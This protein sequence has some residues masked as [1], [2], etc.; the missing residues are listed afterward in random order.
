MSGPISFGYQNLGFGGGSALDPGQL[1][2]IQKVTV[3]AAS[4][5]D[6]TDV[7]TTDYGMYLVQ[8]THFFSAENTGNLEIG[9]FN[10]SGIVAGSSYNWVANE[11]KSNATWSEVKASDAAKIDSLGA[12]GTTQANSGGGYIVI[13]NPAQARG[14]LTMG[15]GGGISDDES[16]F[17]NMLNVGGLAVAEAHTGI[18]FQNAGNNITG[19]FK[20]YAYKD[21]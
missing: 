15:N 3:S 8:F 14:T 13:G 7:F 1:V 20:L 17:Y 16:R 9:F 18:R 6:M 19:T 5:I 4:T 12:A 10:T 2:F 21:S 11:M